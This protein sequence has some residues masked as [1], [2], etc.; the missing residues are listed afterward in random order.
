[1]PQTITT[2]PRSPAI[3]GHDSSQNVSQN[4]DGYAMVFCPICHNL[5][6][7]GLTFITVHYWIYHDLPTLYAWM[8]L[9]ISG[10]A[11]PPAPGWTQLTDHGKIYLSKKA[12]VASHARSNQVSG[13]EPASNVQGCSGKFKNP[14][15]K[16]QNGMCSFSGL[17]VSSS[18]IK[19][20]QLQTG[21]GSCK[22]DQL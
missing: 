16:C 7:L 22:D 2:L 3:W 1:M 19:I 13:V 11:G 21:Q 9:A 12:S 14:E 5:P 4:V 15:I 6:Q 17:R 10:P 20:H 8:L 18:R